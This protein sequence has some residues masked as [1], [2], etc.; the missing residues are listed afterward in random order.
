M[1]GEI[2]INVIKNNQEAVLFLILKAKLTVYRQGNCYFCEAKFSFRF[3]SISKV[4]FI[5]FR[6]MSLSSLREYSLTFVHT[7]EEYM[8]SV[9]RCM[10]FCRYTRVAMSMYL[11][12]SLDRWGD[13]RGGI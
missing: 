5:S 11:F 10:D 2:F 12:G 6:A 9:R 7:C 13:E 8:A 1:F 4:G 3:R